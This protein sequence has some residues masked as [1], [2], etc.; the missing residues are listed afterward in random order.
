MFII[1]LLLA[2]D[3][4]RTIDV[5][6]FENKWNW[7]DARKTCDNFRKY[8]QLLNDRCETNNDKFADKVWHNRFV[9]ERIVWNAGTLYINNRI[10]YIMFLHTYNRCIIRVY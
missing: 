3:G 2:S 4:G 1:Y 6:C 10:V 7:Y 8:I 5:K 9:K